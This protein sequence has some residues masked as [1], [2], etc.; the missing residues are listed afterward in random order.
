MLRFIF[1]ILLFPSILPN[2]PDIF[3]RHFPFPKHTKVVAV[4]QLQAFSDSRHDNFIHVLSYSVHQIVAFRG[5]MAGSSATY[6]FE[7]LCP[8]LS[9]YLSGKS[10][11]VSNL[12]ILNFCR[13]MLIFAKVAKQAARPT[14]DAVFTKPQSGTITDNSPTGD[15]ASLIEGITEVIVERDPP[16]EQLFAPGFISPHPSVTF[17]EVPAICGVQPD[18]VVTESVFNPRRLLFLGETRSPSPK[19]FNIEVEST[20]TGGST[21]TPTNAIS[22]SQQ[23]PIVEAGAPAPTPRPS[24]SATFGTCDTL[25]SYGDLANVE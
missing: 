1:F 12:D 15:Q 19:P 3:Y 11:Y 6:L 20:P 14:S 2:R 17:A 16:E 21:V 13:Q 7:G 18:S 5:D 9:R 23:S 24:S 10:R 8:S 22:T 25:T 4:V